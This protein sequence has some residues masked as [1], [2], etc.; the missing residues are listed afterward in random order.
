VSGSTP[1]NLAVDPQFL[2]PAAGDF[3]T[4]RTSP[5]VAAGDINA[6]NLPSADLDNKARTVCGTIDMGVYEIRPIPPIALTGSPQTAPGQSTVTFTAAVA[7]NCNI[8]T[9]VVTFLD[10]ATIL[11]TAPLNSGGVATFDTSFLFVGTH[12][13]TATYPGDFNFEAS[14][15]NTITEIITGPPTATVLNTVTPIP[16][17]PLQAITM[18]ATVTSAF[19]TPTGNISFTA[20]G[21]VLATVPVTAAGTAHATVSNLRAGTYNITAVY[22]GSTQYAASTSNTIVETVLGANTATTLTAS[23]NPALPARATSAVLCR[24]ER[25]HPSARG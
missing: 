18:T 20:N 19:T 3:H 24:R 6:P 12:P 17:R 23:P 13:I 22:G 1:S 7:G 4:Q 2:N 10:G 16:A 5:V 15:S 8:P 11:G 21:A 14:T 25:L 9:G